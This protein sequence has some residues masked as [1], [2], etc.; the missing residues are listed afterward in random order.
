MGPTQED[1]TVIMASIVKGRGLSLRGSALYL[2][3]TGCGVRSRVLQPLRVPRGFVNRPS[4]FW[5]ADDGGVPEDHRYAPTE[6]NFLSAKQ[7]S[8]TN[9][10]REAPRNSNIT[11]ADSGALAWAFRL[12]P[13]QNSH[14]LGETPQVS[15]IPVYP[16]P[17]PSSPPRS[18]CAAFLTM[19]RDS[20]STCPST[21]EPSIDGLLSTTHPSL[22]M[23]SHGGIHCAATYS[24]WGKT[25]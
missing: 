22:H 10:M 21:N 25:P 24:P 15:K 5:L 8:S 3:A 16:G 4:R 19:Y 17:V 23:T 18:I 11:L 14:Q 7:G 20:F 12:E 6:H 2:R 13:D 9:A 1:G